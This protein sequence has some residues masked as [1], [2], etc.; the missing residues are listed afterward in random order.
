M[1]VSASMVPSALQ[2]HQPVQSAA[3][4]RG[5]SVTSATVDGQPPGSRVSMNSMFPASERK[6][7]FM[8]EDEMSKLR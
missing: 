1:G 6:R 2:D 7:S 3:T 8:P 5:M 4:A